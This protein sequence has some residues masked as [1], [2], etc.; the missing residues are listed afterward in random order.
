MKAGIEV[1]RIR[2]AKSG[3]LPDWPPDVNHPRK[4]RNKIKRWERRDRR[5]VS[6]P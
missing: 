2:C 1:I 6:S 5:D 4:I 3:K